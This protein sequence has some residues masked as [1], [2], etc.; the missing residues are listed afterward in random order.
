MKKG[1]EVKETINH[2]TGEVISSSVV[3]RYRGDEPNYVKLYL[4]DISYLHNLPKRASPILL[5]LL[6]YVT[7]GTQEIMLNAY[8]KKS[9]ASSVGIAMKTL[10]NNLQEFVRS[11]VL[12]RVA[13][14]T[15]KLN[16]YLF[17]KGDWKTIND[18]RNRNIHLKIV[19]DSETN[20]RT[21]RGYI[22]E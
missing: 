21:I 14:G 18:L 10:D 22:D 2:E 6:K 4:E 17:G 12:D 5:E 9:I 19:Y 16:P 3:R 11:G 13:T 8:S 7:Y 20:K 1:I 15:F